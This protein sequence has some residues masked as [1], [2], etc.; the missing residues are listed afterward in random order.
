MRSSGISLDLPPAGEYIAGKGVVSAV[1]K[2]TSEIL[3]WVAEVFEMPA[4]GMRPE[5][6]RDEIQAWD[7]LGILTLI[8]RMDE[9]FQVLLTED[10]IQELRTVG[11]IIGVL[12]KHGRV[13]DAP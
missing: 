12:R 1:A 4:D 10:E 9:D 6:K 13:T 11:D 3:T 5:M 8:A 7:S 2:S